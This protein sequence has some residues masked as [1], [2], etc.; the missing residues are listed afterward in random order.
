MSQL[1]RS[2]EVLG[3]AGQGQ[4]GQLSYSDLYRKLYEFGF[5]FGWVAT[6]LDGFRFQLRCNELIV[7]VAL[8][9]LEAQ[10]RNRVTHLIER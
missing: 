1:S 3:Q 2:L 4:L 5:G 8:P 7:D 6:G 9:G 10:L